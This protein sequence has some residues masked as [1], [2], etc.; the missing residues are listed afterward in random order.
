M[1]PVVVSTCPCPGLF[2][3]CSNK[4]NY[5]RSSRKGRFPQRTQASLSIYVYTLLTIS[6]AIPVQARHSDFH[7]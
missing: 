7:C 1:I 5:R 2:N 4:S 3:E 6:V